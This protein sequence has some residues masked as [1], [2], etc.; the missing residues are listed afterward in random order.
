VSEQDTTAAGRNLR[1]FQWFVRGAAP[2]IAIALLWHAWHTGGLAPV[3]A[4]SPLIALAS[5]LAMGAL[6]TVALL[7]LLVMC[8]VLVHP[9][10]F[11]RW[12][13]PLGL[14]AEGASRLGRR[15]GRAPQKSIPL[16]LWIFWLTVGGA[17]LGWPLLL[18]L[19]PL[20]I[21]TG[22]FGLRT[23]G[24]IPGAWLAALPALVVLL[25]SLA[26]PYLWCRQLCPLGA[27]QDLLSRPT[28]RWRKCAG[29]SSENGLPLARRA[30]LGAVVGAASA[31]VLRP[32]L[33]S[34]PRPLRPPGAVDKPEFLAVCVRCGN[35]T[36]ACPTQIIQPD[37]GWH[38]WTSLLTPTLSFERDYCREDCA[39]CTRVG[40]SGALK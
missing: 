31:S 21:F 34:A 20:V 32:T 1:R 7:G 11:C 23:L 5:M 27:L 37:L 14:C 6:H 19:D 8:I 9:R 16:G 39:L 10:W 30:V 18:W 25:L 38:G 2:A 29:P 15:R 3:P 12:L 33:A 24:R 36:R 22:L 13:C 35:C 17:L 40:P 28:R 4:L 26:W